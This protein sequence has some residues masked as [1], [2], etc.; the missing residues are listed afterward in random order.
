MF[1]RNSSKTSIITRLYMNLIL[2]QILTTRMTKSQAVGAC[3]VTPGAAGPCYQCFEAAY[4]SHFQETFN[5][6]IIT[7][8]AN[9]AA[10][11]L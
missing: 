1:Y 4:C 5:I 10:H 9:R 8:T 2:E 6:Y 11:D 7:V 3:K